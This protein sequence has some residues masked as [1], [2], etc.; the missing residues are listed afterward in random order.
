[1]NV[2]NKKASEFFLHRATTLVEHVS[3]K[4]STDEN[5]GNEVPLFDVLTSV[6]GH[7]LRVHY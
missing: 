4:S 5:S 3:D 6:I 2:C 7:S 1:M